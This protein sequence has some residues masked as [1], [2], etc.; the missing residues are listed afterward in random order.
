MS[1]NPTITTPMN[2]NSQ[3]LYEMS[4]MEIDKIDPATLIDIDSI[5]IDHSLPHEEK[6]LSFIRQ[7]GN[8]Y[9]FVSGGIPVRVRFVGEDKDLAQS[10]VN[11][12]S[13]LKQK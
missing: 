3:T 6:I 9:C 8:P 11:H 10:L 1:Q 2:I 7:A 4:R 13:M 12:F 5:S